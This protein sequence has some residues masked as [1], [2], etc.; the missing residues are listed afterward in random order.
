MKWQ[1]IKFQNFEKELEKYDF[2]Q[3]FQPY[4]KSLGYL[5][6]FKQR[7]GKIWEI[8]HSFTN[9]RFISFDFHVIG[10]KK[11]GCATFFKQ[12][13]F[14]FVQQVD[15]EYNDIGERL[16]NNTNEIVSQVSP[17]ESQTTHKIETAY[18]IIVKFS[19]IDNKFYK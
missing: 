12:N 11:D 3:D 14:H 10:N 18:N 17:N 15:V 1:A 7:T 16:K 5:G 4:F 6:F 2:Q 9:F 8:T 13:K 19:K